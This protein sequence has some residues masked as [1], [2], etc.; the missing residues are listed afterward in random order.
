MQTRAFLARIYSF[1]TKQSRI[2]LDLSIDVSNRKIRSQHHAGSQTV[3]IYRIKGS[4]G[5]SDDFDCD[6]NPTH[7]RTRYRWLSIA[8]AFACGN[9]LPLVELI[10]LG[11]DYFVRDGHHRISVA[12]AFGQ[13]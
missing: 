2:L 4:E 11:E 6:F 1:F 8:V 10:Q 13:D 12:R 5:R 3:P 9:T 7:P